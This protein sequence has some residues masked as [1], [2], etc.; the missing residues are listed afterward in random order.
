MED[1]ARFA[2]AIAA[3]LAATALDA[4][5]SSSS[6]A[7]DEAETRSLIVRPAQSDAPP[8]AGSNGMAEVDADRFRSASANIALIEEFD[9]ADEYPDDRV[10]E[11]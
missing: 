6:G 8:P 10:V 9:R 5:Q 1:R 7:S 11:R 3:I 4:Q 2:L